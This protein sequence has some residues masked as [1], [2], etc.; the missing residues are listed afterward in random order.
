[1]GVIYITKLVASPLLSYRCSVTIN[2]LWFFLAVP[3]VGLQCVVVV[4]PD[5]T[6]LIFILSIDGN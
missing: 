4:F 1:M 6:H 2:V 3:C 5:H